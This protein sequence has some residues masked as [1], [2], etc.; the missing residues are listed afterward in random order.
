MGPD[1]LP[2]ENARLRQGLAEARG[3]LQLSYQWSVGFLQISN[4]EG[5]TVSPYGMSLTK[6]I[7]ETIR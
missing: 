5:D 3:A 2:M 1:F 7:L 6:G 4:G